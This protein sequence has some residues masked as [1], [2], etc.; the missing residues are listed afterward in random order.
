[1][2]EFTNHDRCRRFNQIVGNKAVIDP[3]KRSIE[4]GRLSRVL[5]FTGPTGSGKTTLARLLA[6][7]LLCKNA[8]SNQ[9]DPCGEASC[10]IC[11][12][13]SL[14]QRPDGHYLCDEV[15]A[16]DDEVVAARMDLWR[17]NDPNY[18]VFIDEVQELKSRL[19]LRLRKLVEDQKA[20]II[21]ATTHIDKLDDALKNR[22]KSYTYELRR[23]TPDEVAGYLFAQAERLG[24][25]FGSREQLLRVAHGY[26]CEMRPC[27]KFMGKVL[28]ETDDGAITDI[29]LNELFPTAFAPDQLAKS[30]L[31]RREI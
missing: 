9:A 31:R 13:E 23:P 27:A 19:M 10:P 21:M 30:G 5:L 11:G 16:S 25:K 20:T 14:I 29:Y 12:N 8:P 15:D 3:L 7:R 17:L 22:L 26:Q 6:V 4:R 18:I 1:M 24:V 28:A 2:L